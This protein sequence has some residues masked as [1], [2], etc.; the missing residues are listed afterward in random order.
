MLSGKHAPRCGQRKQKVLLVMHWRLSIDFLFFRSL[1]PQPPPAGTPPTRLPRRRQRVLGRRPGLRPRGP[2]PPKG[3]PGTPV[4]A[5]FSPPPTRPPPAARAEARARAHALVLPAGRGVAW[6]RLPLTDRMPFCAKWA[7]RLT[8]LTPTDAT[9]P[10]SRAG[11]GRG[12]AG[13]DGRGDSKGGS[14][15]SVSVVGG[16]DWLG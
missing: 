10:A 5:T 13:G 11:L 12:V 2:I 9:A 3:G 14:K 1:S 8:Q 4:L 6:R 7:Q 15:G 16:K